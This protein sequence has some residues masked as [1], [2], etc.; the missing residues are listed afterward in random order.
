MIEIGCLARFFNK[1]EDE[2]KFAKE[3]KFDFM[4]LWYDNQGFY[5]NQKRDEDWRNIAA[6]EF[7]SIIHAVLDINDF[8]EHIPKIKCIL[9]GLNHKELIIHPVCKSE[10]ITGRSIEKLNEKIKYVL[11]YFGDKVTI[12]LENNSRLDPIFETAEEIKYIF[13]SNPKLEFLLDIAHI[14][15]YE[16]LQEVIEIKYPKALHIAD[17]RFREIHEH[18]PIGQGEL[19]FG[20]IFSEYLAEFQG[21]IILEV[22]QSDKDIIESKKQIINCIT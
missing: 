13:D 19:D 3:N 1:Y 15:D 22:H 11:D 18:L 12:Y 14:K 20:K 4:Q 5:V 7:P 8:E 6:N 9:D 2:A 16:F 10:E 21:K 17:K